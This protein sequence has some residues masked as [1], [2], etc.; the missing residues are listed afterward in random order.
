MMKFLLV[1]LLAFVLL[2]EAKHFHS[3]I[4]STHH[5]LARKH[6]QKTHAHSHVKGFDGW[7]TLWAGIKELAEFTDDK[8][9]QI[10]K[11]IAEGEPELPV[12][13][14]APAD[15]TAA[16]AEPDSKAGA[17]FVELGAATRVRMRS[18]SKVGDPKT[19]EV[20]ISGKSFI[21]PVSTCGNVCGSLDVA[22]MAAAPLF[23]ASLDVMG[24][25]SDSEAYGRDGNH[26]LF[27]KMTFSLTC[28][29]DG[30][31]S[32]VTAGASDSHVGKEGPLQPPDGEFDHTV[33]RIDNGVAVFGYQFSGR[34]HNLAE[35]SFQALKFRS[36]R[37]IWH[38]PLYR[39]D[40]CTQN[41]DSVTWT[42]SRQFGGSFF[43]T[44]RLWVNTV[45]KV[46]IQQ[47][48]ISALWDSQ[49]GF[50]GFV[51]GE[52]PTGPY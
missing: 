15:A 20:E 29:D 32:D 9:G 51:R 21:R 22:C 19:F 11:K 1:V 41:G 5:R 50:D 6:L 13:A 40:S 44:R 45:E 48:D 35:P 10:D 16:P 3:K 14:D 25:V 8:E 24:V 2:T 30:K 38:F 33:A 7:E 46:T 37:W 12:V 4:R 27:S 26:R 18:K 28:G 49:S 47:G 39:A 23:C 31:I 52:W 43:P 36:C 17:E 42:S 34:P